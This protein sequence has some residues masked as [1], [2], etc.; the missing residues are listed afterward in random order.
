[1]L[2][3]I[4]YKTN[5]LKYDEM[6]RAVKTVTTKDNKSKTTTTSYDYANENERKFVMGEEEKTYDFL[7]KQTSVSDGIE[8]INYTDEK[9]QSVKSYLR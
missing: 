6:N 9:G 8:S 3:N 7:Y 5:Y 4:Q 2:Q 1:M